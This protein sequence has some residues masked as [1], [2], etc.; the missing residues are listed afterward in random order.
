MLQI[1]DVYP[2]SRT[3]IFSI[4][5][6]NFFHPGSRICIREF[7]YFL[8]KKLFFK[9]SEIWS[10]LFIP[11]PAHYFLPRIPGSKRHQIPDPDPQTAKIYALLLLTIS[12]QNISE[13]NLWK[14]PYGRKFFLYTLWVRYCYDISIKKGVGIN[15]WTDRLTFQPGGSEGS[16][17]CQLSLTRLRIFWWSCIT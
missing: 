6:P 10:G 12:S 14:L 1:L 13:Q 3:R 11:D 16:P 2:G 8:T 5:D 9:L 17:G 7:K 15:N 4:P